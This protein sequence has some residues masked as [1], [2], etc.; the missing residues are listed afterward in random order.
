MLF[1]IPFVWMITLSLR[2]SG[3]ILLNPYGLP[4]HPRWGNYWKLMFD[5]AIRFYRYFVNSIIV[6]TRVPADHGAALHAGRL[7]LWPT[8]LQLPLARRAVC[9]L[10][11]LA[12]AAPS[13]PVHPAVRHDGA[14][15]PD[16]HTLGADLD[17]WS[18]GP[19]GEHLP[20]EHLLLA[21]ARRAGRRRTH[22]RRRRP[23]HLL[24]TSCCRSRGRP[25]QPSS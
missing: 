4:L 7:R 19:A 16:Q 18:A 14:V 1:I 13:D 15:P 10:A 20:D 22:R 6:T 17:L 5:P 8:A 23:A 24:A 21:I 3:D 25:W 12:H 11:V 2:T 9:A